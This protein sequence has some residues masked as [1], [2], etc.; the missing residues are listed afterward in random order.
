SLRR[1]DWDTE[2]SDTIDRLLAQ[3]AQTAADPQAPLDTRL[4]AIHLLTFDTF[5]R[6]GAAL[7]ELLESKQRHEVQRAAVTAI[8]SFSQLETA[9]ML[10]SKWR[11][12]APAIRSE[13]VLAML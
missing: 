3:A 8:G 7:V 2:T 1:A 6:A 11:A 9:S 13:I 5:D 10:L 12:S 4:A